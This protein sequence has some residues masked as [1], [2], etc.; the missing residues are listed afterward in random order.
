MCIAPNFYP[1]VLQKESGKKKIIFQ[2]PYTINYREDLE[3]MSQFADECKKACIGFGSNASLVRY[4][5]GKKYEFLKMVSV[6][7]GICQDCLKSHARDWAVRIMA[8]TKAHEKNW[9]ITLTYD[10]DHLPFDGML[11]KDEISKFNKK[12]KV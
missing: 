8:E 1:L 6:P 2:L 5:S 12:L 10:D 7:C 4:L 9:F 11:V 3:N